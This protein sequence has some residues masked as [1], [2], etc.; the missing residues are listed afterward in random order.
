MAGR[1]HSYRGRRVAPRRP[2]ARRSAAL[3]PAQRRRTVQLV[4]CGGIFVLLAAAKLL[5]PEGIAALSRRAADLLGRDSDFQA[6]FSAVGRAIAGE[7][8]V[9]D[10]LQEAY[11]AVFAPGTYSAEPAAALDVTAAADR[12]HTVLPTEVPTS[13]GG[14]P[15]QEQ[16]EEVEETEEEAEATLSQSYTFFSLP[17]PEQVSMA[18]EVLGFSYTTPLVG[19]LTSP[20]GWREHPVYGEGRFHYGIDI[21]GA[22][23]GTAI[24]SFA[25]GTVKA[26]GESASLGRYLM[27][28]HQG[29]YT[30]LYAHC[31]RVTAS[32]GQEVA[33]GDKVAEVGSTGIT[34]GP[35][36]HFELHRDGLY[37]NPIY[38]VEV[39]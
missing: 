2:A 37:L 7:E 21:G 38:Y 15:A 28:D 14:D 1:I 30:T 36:L 33:M 6:A 29:G 23:E 32:S 3:T 4:I 27:I 13:D 12:L 31:S 5:F 35:H 18:Q 8:P 19:P 20:F 34:T 22:P 24:V 17:L 39:S 16:E 10:S 9:G 26:V 25:A 11:T